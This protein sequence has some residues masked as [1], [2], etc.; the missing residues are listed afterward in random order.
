MKSVG[1]SFTLVGMMVVHCAVAYPHPTIESPVPESTGLI[2]GK[3]PV[4]ISM[5]YPTGFRDPKAL[6]S[7]MPVKEPANPTTKALPYE[8][9]EMVGKQL[10]PLDLAQVA[11]VSKTIRPMPLGNK[12]YTKAAD[13]LYTKISGDYGIM[14]NGEPLSH[15][16]Q[17]GADD[18]DTIL[19][20]PRLVPGLQEVYADWCYVRFDQLNR[21]K[22]SQ[23]FPLVEFALYNDVEQLWDVTRKL[24]RRRIPKTNLLMRVVPIGNLIATDEMLDSEFASYISDTGGN[25]FYTSMIP[26]ITGALAAAKQFDKLGTYIAKIQSFSTRSFQLMN[27]LDLMIL[28]F[29]LTGLEQDALEEFGY[30]RHLVYRYPALPES[31]F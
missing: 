10:N 24:A 16:N 27:F 20:L 9:L 14:P 12:G 8:L 11:Q 6:P 22:L 3:N 19:A 25:T 23:V 31:A 2:V 5:G 15:D 21:Q 26:I 30:N 29:D 18:Q 13:W 28:G 17:P 7:T 1:Y 4:S